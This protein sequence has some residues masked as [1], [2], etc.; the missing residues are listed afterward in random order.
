MN[1]AVCIAGFYADGESCVPCAD[2]TYN[3]DLDQMSCSSC[4]GNQV[5]MV[6]GATAIGQCGKLH[7]LLTFN[8]K[9]LK[10]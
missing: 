7:A 2:G 6:T 1:F 5:A 3:G 4:P 10:Q 9:Q 8:L